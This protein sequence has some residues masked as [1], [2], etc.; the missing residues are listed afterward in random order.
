MKKQY[1]AWAIDSNNGV[2]GLVGQ[3]WWFDGNPPRIPNHMLGTKIALFDTRQFARD[4]LPAT[5]R[6]FPK[7][8]VVKVNVTLE[9]E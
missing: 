5:K 7:A 6:A 9:W 2:H 8:K 1:E 4:H 3:F